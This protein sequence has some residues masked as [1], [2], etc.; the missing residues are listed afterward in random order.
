MSTNAAENSHDVES[1]A[2]D[3]I[4]TG[5]SDTYESAYGV[6]DYSL[7][8]CPLCH[9][10]ENIHW[11]FHAVLSSWL[12]FVSCEKCNENWA[13]CRKCSRFRSR[14]SNRKDILRHSLKKHLEDHEV[15][16][17]CDFDFASGITDAV[18]VEDTF[19]NHSPSKSSIESR[20]E[21]EASASD[22]IDEEVVTAVQ[23]KVS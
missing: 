23:A 3:S 19:S 11:N 15:T 10:H 20:L 2:M 13:L 4:I 7:T 21:N 14:L 1:N 9:T 12:V 6:A 8:L 5:G 18:G 22:L 16:K 17:T